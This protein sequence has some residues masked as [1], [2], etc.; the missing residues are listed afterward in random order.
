M[1]ETI[2]LPLRNYRP[3]ARAVA[4]VAA[5]TESGDVTA[6]LLHVFDE[7]E[8]SSTRE[9]ID[10]S[11]SMTAN[12]L[13]ARKSGIVAA[14]EI[15]QDAGV[16]VEVR[17][18]EQAETTADSILTVADEAGVERLYLY[19]RKRSPTGKAVFGSTLQRILFNATVPVTVVPSN[20]TE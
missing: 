14:R 3:W 13:A 12:D 4:N 10:S 19:G 18:R 16:S 8:L 7:D 6:L 5:N 9:N 11:G 15:L 20:V 1:S 2:L 17:G